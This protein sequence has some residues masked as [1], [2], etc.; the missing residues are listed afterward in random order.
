MDDT[1]ALKKTPLHALHLSRGARMVPFAGYDMPVQYPAGVM[2]EHLHTRTEVGL[3]DVSHMGQVIVKA[4]SGSYE[5]AALALESLVPVDILG[6]AEGRQRYGFF[7]DNSG[8]ILDD[9]MI[10]HLDDHLFVVVNASCK[11]AD[12]AHLQ[13]HIGDRCDI[14][15]LNRALIALQGP[16][17]VE[18]LAELWADVAAMKFMDVRHCRLHDVSCL[19]SRSGYSGEDG[20]EISIPADKAEDV[21]MRLLEHPDVQA[22]GLGARDSLRLEAG[23]CLYG[24]D[25]DTTTSPVEA[26]LEWAM[27]KARRTGGARAGGFPGSGRILSELENGAARRRVGLKPEGKA[28]VRGHAKLYADAEGKVEIGEVTSG[29]F[30]PSVEGPVAMGYV[31]VSHAAAGTLVY[32]EVRGKYLPITVSALPFVT[33]TYKR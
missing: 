10:A 24:N 31:P 8:C 19:V 27:Q 32:A 20:F 22:I 1:A 3:F 15:L 16:R 7:T 14:T 18:V 17:A 25:I 5:D 2:K 21:T 12:L 11:E 9:L 30:G 23:L 6:L 26:A 33:P 13:A 28:P 4:K 29:G